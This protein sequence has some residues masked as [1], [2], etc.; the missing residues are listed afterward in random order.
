MAISQRSLNRD[1]A[2]ALSALLGPEAK[3][4]SSATI[5]RLKA[6]WQEE[7][8]AWQTRSMRHK[9]YVYVWADGIYFNIRDDER[10]CIL[11]MIGVTDTGH[12][13]LL[14]METGYRESALNWKTLML[15]LVDQG[16]QHD[17]LL[18]IGDGALAL[19]SAASGLAHHPDAA[20]LGTQDGE[21]P[22]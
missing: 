19:E 21:R 10:Q 20:V 22:Q 1:F 12:K 11:V 8:S 2:E 5:S 15:R 7:H 18:A 4:L 9:R 3:G 13:E 6:K 14:G 17:P 16:L